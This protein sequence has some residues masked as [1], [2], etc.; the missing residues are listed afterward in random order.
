MQDGRTSRDK[1]AARRTVLRISDAKF[2]RAG[3]GEMVSRRCFA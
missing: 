3:E 2:M 1:A